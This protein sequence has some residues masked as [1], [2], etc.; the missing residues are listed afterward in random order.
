MQAEYLLTT[1]LPIVGATVYAC[2]GAYLFALVAP[3][4]KKIYKRW[5]LALIFAFIKCALWPVG[6]FIDTR[7]LLKRQAENL[8][9][10]GF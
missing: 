6:G 4:C 2:I 3:I 8:K 10:M 9:Y 5:I 1:V 7:A